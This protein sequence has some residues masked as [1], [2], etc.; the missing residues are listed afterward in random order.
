[1]SNYRVSSGHKGEAR[2]HSMVSFSDLICRHI[3]LL[4]FRLFFALFFPLNE[5]LLVCMLMLAFDHYEVSVLG[6]L[7]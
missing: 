6:S 1:M 7:P 2:S 4:I 5:I 3:C